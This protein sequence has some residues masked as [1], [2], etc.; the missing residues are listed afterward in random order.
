MKRALAG[1]LVW[2]LSVACYAQESAQPPLN[3]AAP[4]GGVDS[5]LVKTPADPASPSGPGRFYLPIEKKDRFIQLV[6]NPKIVKPDYLTH[7]IAEDSIYLLLGGVGSHLASKVESDTD[8]QLGDAL[9]SASIDVSSI[10]YADILAQLTPAKDSQPSP[11]APWELKLDVV[12]GSYGFARD[13]IYSA[14][15]F[16]I[17][18]IGMRL[19]RR[20]D[21]IVWE[22]VGWLTASDLGND[23][24]FPLEDYVKDP[25]KMKAAFMKISPVITKKL[26]GSMRKNLLKY[27][28]I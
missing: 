2:I 11:V 13:K 25:E 3:P 26:L 14:K 18:K 27:Y 23:L 6:V 22:E 9:R 15:L 21:E 19:Y 12:I 16:P 28:P 5:S 1:S 17:L 4:S 24:G 10:V 8:R 20:A 7:V